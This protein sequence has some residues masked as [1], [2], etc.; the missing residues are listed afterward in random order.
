MK[1]DNLCYNDFKKD[2]FMKRKISYDYADL[3]SELNEELRDGI[4]SLD[5]TI[6]I[7]RSDE[8]ITRYYR[9]VV[10]WYYSDEKMAECLDLDSSNRRQYEQDKLKLINVSVRDCHYEIGRASCRERV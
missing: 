2:F 6:Q 10:D 3:I 7:L 9:P 1:F 5:D 4:L 8:E